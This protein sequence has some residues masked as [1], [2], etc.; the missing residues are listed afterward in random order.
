MCTYYKDNIEHLSEALQSIID[1]SYLPNE[2][3]LVCDGPLSE[4]AYKLLENFSDVCKSKEIDCNLIKLPSNVGIGK[5]R[6]I[7]I[8]HCTESYIVTMDSDDICAKD[9]LFELKNIIQEDLDVE[10]IGTYIEEFEK[11]PGDLKITKKVPL[12]H[13]DIKNYALKRNPINNVTTC[14]KKSIIT[15]H[16]SFEDHTTHEDYLYWLKL[17]S[18]GV[19]FKNVPFIHV[20][21]RVD[22]FINRRRGF[23]YLVSEIDFVKKAYHANYMSLMSCFLFIVPRLVLRLLPSNV[24]TMFYRNFLRAI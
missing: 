4:G 18:K 8:E 15:Q 14:F 7:G 13:Y 12:S 10:V 1:Q 11:V 22:K 3:V 23:K 21:V 24:L 20:Y 2:F 5:A 9:R 19:K 17:L 6:K 16:G